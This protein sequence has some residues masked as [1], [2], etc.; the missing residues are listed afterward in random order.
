MK[1]LL[2]A[3][4]ETKNERTIKKALDLI[5]NGYL[6]AGIDLLEEIINNLKK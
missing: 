4:V 2:L 5:K 6:D 3:S 1:K